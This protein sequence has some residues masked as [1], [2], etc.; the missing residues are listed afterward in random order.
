MKCSRKGCNETENLIVEQKHPWGKRVWYYCAKHYR[1]RNMVNCANRCYKNTPKLTLE[2]LET[3]FSSYYPNHN[4]LL[5]RRCGK[6]MIWLER[7]GRKQDIISLQHCR[8]GSLE[9]W[10]FACNAGEAMSNHKDKYL[11]QPKGTKICYVCGEILSL[12]M[13]HRDRAFPDGKK[14][15]CKKCDAGLQRKY[16]HYKG[17]SK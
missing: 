11:T 4:D 6:K 7:D 16:K 17:N 9:F 13:F 1:F 2:N 8:N 5:C 14:Y 10:C 15:H 3:L 12:E